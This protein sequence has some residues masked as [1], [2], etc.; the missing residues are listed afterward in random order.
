MIGIFVFTGIAMLLGIILVSVEFYFSRD[1]RKLEE[2]EKMLP[3]YNCGVC[4]FGGCHGMAEAIME[5]KDAYLRCRPMKA[6]AKEKLGQ[7]LNQK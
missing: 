7:Y 4:G 1:S 5:D 3:G 2:V 6:E